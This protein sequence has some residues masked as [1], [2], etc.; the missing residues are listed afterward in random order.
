M[1]Q[2]NNENAKQSSVRMEKFEVPQS[3]LK[4]NQRDQK[5]IA[6]KE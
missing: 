3:N 4:E 1:R 6:V 5:S 2:I